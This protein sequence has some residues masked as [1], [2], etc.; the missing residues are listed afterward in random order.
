M[1]ECGRR[2]LSLNIFIVK[3]VYLLW[4]A[5]KL[6]MW[7]ISYMRFTSLDHFNPELGGIPLKV[8]LSIY[9]FNC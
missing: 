5:V 6:E 7:C 9:L 1:V 2:L 4:P 8:E 3:P